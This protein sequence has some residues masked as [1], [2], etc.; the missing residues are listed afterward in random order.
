MGKDERSVDELS[1]KENTAMLTFTLTASYIYEMKVTGVN[2]FSG[3]AIGA[4][5]VH[6]RINFVM[7]II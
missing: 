5:I 1:A 6:A 2:P 3:P 4:Y 7:V